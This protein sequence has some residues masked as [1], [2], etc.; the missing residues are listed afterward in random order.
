M[1][2]KSP[3]AKCARAIRA[4]QCA[5]RSLAPLLCRLRSLRNADGKAARD[6]INRCGE[7]YLLYRPIYL[8]ST[9]SFLPNNDMAAL[10]RWS[11]SAMP[12]RGAAAFN[13]QRQPPEIHVRPN[14][15]C[16]EAVNPENRIRH[17]TR[18]RYRI[19]AACVA[20]I[21]CYLISP[22]WR[23]SDRPAFERCVGPPLGP[24]KPHPRLM[25]DLAGIVHE[26]ASC[27]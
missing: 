25:L 16:A 15:A 4:Q 23:I 11:T 21:K 20:T 27:C 19:Y 14:A 24:S 6:L 26:N 9:I 10:Y 12:V 13:R 5:N 17:G 3:R 18:E 1:R 22:A 8:Y 7:F 2:P